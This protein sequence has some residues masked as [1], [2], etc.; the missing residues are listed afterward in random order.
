MVFTEL[1]K[2]QLRWRIESKL[3]LLQQK[4]YALM[5][6]GARTQKWHSEASSVH[7]KIVHREG[8]IKKLEEQMEKDERH[9]QEIKE[10]W[11]K[12]VYLRNCKLGKLEDG[13]RTL[14]SC[15]KGLRRIDAKVYRVLSGRTLHSGM[16]PPE[17]SPDEFGADQQNLCRAGSHQ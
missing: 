17:P 15:R 4:Q 7:G 16:V 2:E 14:Q 9:V 3:K 8:I 13:S 11:D 12:A 1:E 5:S 10:M 6:D